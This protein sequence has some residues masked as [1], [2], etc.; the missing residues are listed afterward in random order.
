MTKITVIGE[1]PKEEKKLKPIEFIGILQIDGNSISTSIGKKP[2][3]FQEIN[4]VK[5]KSYNFDCICLAKS[6]SGNMNVYTANFNDG[7]AE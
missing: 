7:V 3:D 5:V 1:A 2:N 4:V 6:K